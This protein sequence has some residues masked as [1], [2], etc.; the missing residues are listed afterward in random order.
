MAAAGKLRDTMRHSWSPEGRRESVAEHSWRTALMAY[1]VKDEFPAF[2]MNKV[3][4]MCIVHDLGEVFTGDVPS[5]YKTEQNEEDEENALLKWVEKLPP[6][7]AEE[8]TELYGE[9]LA[10]KTNEAKLYKAL[11]NMEAVIS[12]N[13][14]DISTWLP[15]EYE[16]NVTYGA[17]TA[18]FSDYLSKVR[19][20]LAEETIRKI[21][22]TK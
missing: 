11:D 9:M 5:F 4:R 22:E 6:P 2:D 13:E 15:L 20:C 17:D 1:F 8:L 18:A 12:H 10:L 16:L 14:A 19:K 7:Y 3:M 21:E